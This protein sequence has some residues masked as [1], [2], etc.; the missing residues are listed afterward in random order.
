MSCGEVITSLMFI[1]NK[2]EYGPFGQE[3][4]KSF[5]SPHG[6][7]IV[8]FFGRAATYLDQIGVVVEAPILDP[9]VKPIS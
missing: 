4:G 6:K 8:G 7:K 3:I 5:E 1:S 2:K 9:I